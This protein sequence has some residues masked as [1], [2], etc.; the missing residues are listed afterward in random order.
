[1]ISSEIFHQKLQA[2]QIQEALALVLNDGSE[3]DV[4]TQMTEVATSQSSR[5][6][7]LRTKI[8]LLT[9]EIQN[10]VGKDLVADSTSYI[11]LQQLHIDQI[12]VSHRLV[13]GYLDRIKAILTVLDSSSASSDRASIHHPQPSDRRLSSADL[14][15]RLTQAAASSSPPSISQAESERIYAASTT[16]RHV[17]PPPEIVSPTANWE[18]EQISPNQI[19][20][21][22]IDRDDD[23]DLSLDP[24]GTI[25][26]EWIEDEDFLSGSLLP[27]PSTPERPEHW[28]KQLHP[29]A[30]KPTMR[31]TTESVNTHQ[32]DRFEPEYINTNPQPPH[33][34]ASDPPQLDRLQTDLD[35]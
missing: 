7:Y 15:T 34:I 4:T 24:D 6:A 16:D 33:R 21:R 25:W 3:L 20:P 32:W 2:G 31:T 11:K 30:V 22:A 13:Q 8:N 1:M 9:G 14:V 23:L 18:G 10:E 26:E 29:I 19:D 17:M 12:V 35:K 28:G 27:P 5:S